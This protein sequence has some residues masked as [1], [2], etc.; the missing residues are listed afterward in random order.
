M[1][2]ENFHM[3]EKRTNLGNELSLQTKQVRLFAHRSREV[4]VLRSPHLTLGGQCAFRQLALLP[5]PLDGPLVAADVRAVVAF[6]L[7]SMWAQH[8][9]RDPGGIFVH[10]WRRSKVAFAQKPRLR[11]CSEN[12]TN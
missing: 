8:K 1:I 4:I 11:A 2:A 10:V 6:K 5:Q 9:M 12:T 3:G 7:S